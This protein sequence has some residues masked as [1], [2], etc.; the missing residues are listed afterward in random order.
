MKHIGIIGITAL[1]SSL[2]YKKIVQKSFLRNSVFPVIHPEITVNNISFSDY[3]NAGPTI[4]DGWRRVHDLILT[5][6][7]KV[8]LCGAKFVIIPANTVHH[9]FDYLNEKSQLKILNIIDLTVKKCINNNV[10]KILI[11]GTHFTNDSD[12]YKKNLLKSGIE[13]VYLEEEL[14]KVLQHHIRRL[15]SCQDLD[16]ES[17]LK[18]VDKINLMDC[19]SILLGC[20]E[21]TLIADMFVDKKIIIDSL[22]VICDEALNYSLND[23]E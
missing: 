17:I 16:T 19:D 1:G 20:T 10:K 6:I 13:C 2:C 22:D 12:L 23:K 7:Y 4:D 3:Y 21:L 5:S 8:K 15:S 14:D 11:L 18:L 9:D